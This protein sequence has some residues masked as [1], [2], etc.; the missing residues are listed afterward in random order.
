MCEPYKP[1]H[2]ILKGC[3]IF[4]VHNSELIKKNVAI[5]K[6]D[7]SFIK[8]VINNGVKPSYDT[9]LA[10]A[11]LGN[12][13]IVKE[14]LA[15]EDIFPL[16]DRLFGA[17]CESGNLE[18]IKYLEKNKCPYCDDSLI[19]I[20]GNNPSIDVINYAIKN[21]QKWDFSSHIS[22]NVNILTSAIGTGNLDNV[23][24]V[25][26]SLNMKHDSYLFNGPITFAK[27]APM[28]AACSLPFKI[29]EKIIKYLLGIK[30]IYDTTVL[31][32]T[33]SIDNNDYKDIIKVWELMFEDN[34]F[35]GGIENI[36][37]KNGSPFIKKINEIFDNKFL[38]K[39]NFYI[40]EDK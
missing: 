27:L 5:A 24:F 31:P 13:K 1:K 40:D 39:H 21:L 14:L 30:I 35:V 10:A 34:N 23:K 25:Y 6:G 2:W 38:K 26:N 7:I 9:I 28:T 4:S 17:A 37:V 8:Q 16:T 29:G 20:V 19:K 18:L 36:T 22:Y 11:Q 3:Y 33:D 32:W 15:Y 12:Y